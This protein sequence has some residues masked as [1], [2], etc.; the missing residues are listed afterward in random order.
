MAKI[1]VGIV[2]DSGLMRLVISDIVNSDPELEVI[3]TGTNGKEAVELVRNHRPDVL[4]LD[5]IM[6]EYD[7]NYAIKQ[8]MKF[9]PIPIIVLSGL[10]DKD[11][12]QITEIL[13]RGAYDF[14][15]KPHGR[16][17]HIRDINDTLNTKIKGA[18]EGFNK[19]Q[20]VSTRINSNPH[21]FVDQLNYEAIVVGSSTGGPTTIEKFLLQLPENLPVPVIIAQHMPANFIVPY[22]GRLDRA[23]PFKVT[24][25]NTGD[26]VESGTVYI[27]SG[28]AN[29]TLEMKG[30][31]VVFGETK[32]RFKHFNNPSVDAL[33]ISAAEVYKNKLIGIVFTGMGADG[34]QGIIRIKDRGGRTIAQDKE[35][36]VVYGMPKEAAATGKVD[37]VLP[38]NDMGGFVVTCLS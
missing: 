9:R 1:R 30:G 25:A 37:H 10:N 23:C 15:S 28:H 6:G 38:L 18:V 19:Q 4:V 22:A 32:E 8:I 29:Q 16:N 33:F 7:G 31:R 27:L 13:E 14:I 2:D 26:R 5:M 21:T 20:N 3:A 12:T 17:Q 24:H 11:S 34:S 35:S 36:S